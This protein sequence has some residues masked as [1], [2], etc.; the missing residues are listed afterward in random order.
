MKKACVKLLTVTMCFALLLSMGSLAARQASGDFE[1]IESRISKFMSDNKLNDGNFSFSYYNTVTGE[2]FGF[3]E[4]KMMRV[5][6]VYKLPLNMYYY[7]QVALGAISPNARFA[8]YPLS[9]CHMLSLRDSDNSTSQAMRQAI[10][11]LSAFKIAIDKYTGVSAAEIGGDYLHSNQFSSMTIMNTLKY[12][13][14][15]SEFFSE[16]LGYLKAANPRQF[17]KMYVEDYEIAQKYGWLDMWPQPG[18]STRRSRICFVW[19]LS[20]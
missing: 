7:E 18:S 6:S 15:N 16:A 19:P 5:G 3:N 12:L 9:Q 14:D 2:T 13:Y 17:F 20:A 11:G 4:D 8:G 10:G 1:P